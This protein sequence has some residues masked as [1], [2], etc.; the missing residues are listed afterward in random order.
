VRKAPGATPERSR[1]AV[2]ARLS[3]QTRDGMLGEVQDFVVEDA[4]WA[5]SEVFVDTRPWWPG[6]HVGYGRRASSQSIPKAAP[7]TCASRA[8]SSAAIRPF[9]SLKRPVAIELALQGGGAHGAF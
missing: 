1:S 3:V 5:I 2:D 7:C 9:I 4:D 6:G 8:K